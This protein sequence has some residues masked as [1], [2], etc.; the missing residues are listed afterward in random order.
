MAD[1]RRRRRMFLQLDQHPRRSNEHHRDVPKDAHVFEHR[2]RQ[3]T[4]LRSLVG[5]SKGSNR[6]TVE[7]V[8]PGIAPGIARFDHRR[9]SQTISN[10]CSSITL[11]YI[12]YINYMIT[13]AHLSPYTLT[14]INYINST[15]DTTPE[16]T[17]RLTRLMPCLS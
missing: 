7:A 1:S 9:V 2:N 12:N 3:P 11:T 14:Y 5:T 17:F 6:R 15:D 16:I 13:I 10:H 8:T 4:F